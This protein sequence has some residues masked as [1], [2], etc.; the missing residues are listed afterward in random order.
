MTTFNFYFPILQALLLRFDIT[1]AHLK[2][3]H[4]MSPEKYDMS[5]GSIL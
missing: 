4:L 5:E 3:L 1:V 2:K